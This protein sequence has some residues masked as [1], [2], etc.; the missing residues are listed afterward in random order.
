MLMQVFGYC[1]KLTPKDSESVPDYAKQYLTEDAGVCLSGAVHLYLG[2]IGATSD[3]TAN[4]VLPILDD[5]LKSASENEVDWILEGFLSI[6][7]KVDSDSKQLIKRNAELQLDAKKK[8]TQN[9]AKKILRR[10]TQHNMRL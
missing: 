10:L 1:A 3:K 2:R 4:V 5:A 7:D 9:R 8:S 6:I